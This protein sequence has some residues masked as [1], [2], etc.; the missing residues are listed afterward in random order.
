MRSSQAR[1][2]GT[3]KMLQKEAVVEVGMWKHSVAV[4]LYLEG[5]GEVR[6][7]VKWDQRLS[8]L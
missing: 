7:N 4:G 5:S 6:Q 8:Q 1:G 2:L 3:K